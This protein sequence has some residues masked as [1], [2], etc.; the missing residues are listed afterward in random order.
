MSCDRSAQQTCRQISSNS[1]LHRQIQTLR[2]QSPLQRQGPPRSPASLLKATGA[3]VA[4]ASSTASDLAGAQKKT[5]AIGA[6]KSADPRPPNALNPG[7]TAPGTFA[8]STPI[9][10]VAAPTLFS[11][12]PVQVS[13]PAPAP[14][15]HSAFVADGTAPSI[16]VSQPAPVLAHVSEP[17]SAAQFASSSANTVV[18]AAAADAISAPHADIAPA[19]EENL[20][21]V[22]G[23]SAQHA[24]GSMEANPIPA[25]SSSST[26][27]VATLPAVATPVSDSTVSP[28]ERITPDNSISSTAVDSTADC[29]SPQPEP[30]AL[31]DPADAQPTQP[32]PQTQP[33]ENAIQPPASNL[34]AAESEARFFVITPPAKPQPQSALENAGIRNVPLVSASTPQTPP[35]V[36]PAAEPITVTDPSSRT[37]PQDH[38]ASSQ[39]HVPM[40][41]K[42]S[43]LSQVAPAT[44]KFAESAGETHSETH[45]HSSESARVSSISGNQDDSS[46]STPLKASPSGNP[47][48]SLVAANPSPPNTAS[49]PLNT[50]A[51]ASLGNALS[52]ETQDPATQNPASTTLDRPAL[53]T[54]GNGATPPVSTGP[55]QQDGKHGCQESAVI[56]V[57]FWESEARAAGIRFRNGKPTASTPRMCSVTAANVQKFTRS[58]GLPRD[59]VLR[60]A[61]PAPCR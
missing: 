24:P 45:P 53:P 19:S 37:V 57:H 10:A 26:L 11:A 1:P 29:S 50:P 15:T 8:D 41:L 2:Q 14:Q 52:P 4:A 3:D 23:S 59:Q 43:G 48:P 21:P 47:D 30:A 22:S 16:S 7:R 27:R 25:S 38:P 5:P 44:G 18:P 9:L 39:I 55:V 42:D 54:A 40:G 35:N 49:L 17:A 20:A 32:L 46:L 28:C 61:G 51:P 12:M 34:P 36:T 60:R 31:A 13:K 6:P 58:A 56:P 33:T